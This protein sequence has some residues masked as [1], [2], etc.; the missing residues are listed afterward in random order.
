MSRSRWP[1]LAPVRHRSSPASDRS[2]AQGCPAWFQATRA[3]PYPAPCRPATPRSPARVGRA[4]VPA[5]TPAPVRAVLS[6]CWPPRDPGSARCGRTVPLGRRPVR[7]RSRRRVRSGDFPTLPPH[8]HVHPAH[9]RR[10]SSWPRCRQ[11]RRAGPGGVNRSCYGTRPART[12]AS[13][14][15]SP[16][17]VAV[18]RHRK[19]GCRDP[20]ARPRTRP[21]SHGL[22]RQTPCSGTTNAP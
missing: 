6:T 8:G 12:H 19:R 14:S 11:A 17:P 20:E 22:T 16:H 13:P 10:P 5:D 18:Y 2:E 15:G 1:A 9:R 3:S 4:A 7:R 21:R